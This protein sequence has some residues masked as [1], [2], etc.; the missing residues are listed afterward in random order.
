MGAAP[1][2]Q[3][4]IPAIALREHRD[5]ILP[6]ARTFTADAAARTGRKLAGLTPAAAQQPHRCGRSA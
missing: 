2:P 6:L 1:E 5:D 3:A 4:R